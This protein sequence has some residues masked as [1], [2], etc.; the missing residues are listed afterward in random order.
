MKIHTPYIFTGTNLTASNRIALAPMTN[1]QSHADGRLSDDEY[2]WLIRRAKEGFGIIFTC[3]VNVSKGGKGW[4]G[5]LGAWDDDH[6]PGLKR[7]AEGIRHYGSI[8][9]VQLFH[10]GARSPESITG[11][12]A[13]SASEYTIASGHEVTHIREATDQ[14]I[15][16]VIKDFTDAAIR[17]YQ[18]GFN[19]VELHGAHGY[20]LHQFLSTETNK[21]KDEW[22]GNL[23]N[24]SRLL[25]TILRSI[26]KKVPDDFLIGVRISPEDKYNFKG[27]DFDE[28]L[29]LAGMLEKE[30]IHFLDLSPWDALKTPDKYP[31]KEKALITYFRELLSK[32]IAIF[33]AG[34]IWSATD[35]EKAIS[36]GADF[37]SLGRVA[38]AHP[39]WPTKSDQTE[40][41]PARPPFSTEHLRSADLGESF[42]EYM[43][44]W[45]GFVE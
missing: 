13:W 28:S 27:I 38:I 33:V 35:A 41:N 31:D 10:G 22:G 32:D 42:I 11:Q 24:R 1:T 5:E 39:D 40:Y 14:D 45:K 4:S 9:I 3:A 44:R 15:E 12:Q 2:N 29:E 26:K 36:L 8:G 43:R 25:I 16:S 19:G 18:A 37:V 17:V 20:L 30:R 7:L 6:L 23:E 21:R 34:E